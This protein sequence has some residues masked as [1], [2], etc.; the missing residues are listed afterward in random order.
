MNRVDGSHVDSAA[1]IRSLALATARKHKKWAASDRFFS[2]YIPNCNKNGPRSHKSSNII[3]L[4]SV[5]MLKIFITGPSPTAIGFHAPRIIKKTFPDCAKSS[6]ATLS[7]VAWVDR[8][9][10][11][12]AVTVCLDAKLT[13]ESEVAGEGAFDGRP[14]TKALCIRR[15]CGEILF[16]KG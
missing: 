1:V 16:L 8:A 15:V 10:Y 3:S 2:F 6:V 14:S 11:Y 13:A 7:L 4:G 5:T 12:D 9:V